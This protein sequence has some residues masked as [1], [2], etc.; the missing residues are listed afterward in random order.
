MSLQDKKMIC[1]CEPILVNYFVKTKQKEK[2]NFIKI[3]DYKS[4]IMSDLDLFENF[5][6]LKQRFQS[7]KTISS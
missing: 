6:I 4:L 5:H 1:M 2:T 7:L 3:R